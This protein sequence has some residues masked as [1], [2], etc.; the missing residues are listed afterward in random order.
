ML[1]NYVSNVLPSVNYCHNMTSF[2]KLNWRPVE[3][4]SNNYKT[5]NL[6][7]VDLQALQLF[8]GINKNT[9]RNS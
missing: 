5:I 9:M 1:L 8:I 4:L 2:L 6:S 3:L 7:A